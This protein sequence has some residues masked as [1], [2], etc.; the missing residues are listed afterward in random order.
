MRNP[1]LTYAT[2]LLL[3][4]VMLGLPCSALLAAG[5]S[6]GHECCEEQD[7][8]SQGLPP[9]CEEVCAAS[10]NVAAKAQGAQL[11]HTPLI[12]ERAPQT[13]PLI[14]AHATPSPEVRPCAASCLYLQHSSLLI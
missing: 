4:A 14:S 12:S 3:A 10:Q 5:H 1:C 9:G 7:G 8:S 2:T 13:R 11:D 6:S